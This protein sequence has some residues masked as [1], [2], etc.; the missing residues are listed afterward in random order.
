MIA[1]KWGSNTFFVVVVVVIYSFTYLIKQNK[2]K[3]KLKHRKWTKQTNKQ[4][5]RAQEKAQET[6]N[7][8]FT[9]TEESHK[10]TRQ[11]ALLYARKGPGADLRGP[12]AC[13]LG[14]CEFL[15]VLIMLI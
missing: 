8:L 1:S 7:R 10:N 12:C 13:G 15:G 11:E 6:Q 3:Q 2:T 14:L 9:H 5:K 4:T